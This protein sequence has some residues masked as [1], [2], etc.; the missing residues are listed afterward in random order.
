[1]PPRRRA[2]AGGRKRKI[3][4]NPKNKGAF[5]RQ[6]KAAR[7]GVQAYARRVLAAPKG[8]YSPKTR[9]RAAFAKGIGGA[10][11]RRARGR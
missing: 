3:R 6:A 8:R 7:M 11:R 10:S 9:Q 1:M 5:T 4:V 2:A